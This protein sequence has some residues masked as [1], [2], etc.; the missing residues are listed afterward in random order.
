MLCDRAIRWQ[1]RRPPA[2][3]IGI[4][5]FAWRRGHTYASIVVDLERRQVIDLLPDWQC[6]TVMAWL[7]EN[8]QVEII[9]RDRGP[10]YVAA[11][12]EAAPRARQVAD[13]W[14][15]F[16]NASAACLPAVRS[17]IPSLRRA[18]SPSGPVDPATLTRAERLQWDGVQI[19]ETLNRQIL[20]LAG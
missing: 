1:N 17:E 7:R 8:P 6:E 20:D 16:E 11:A 12:T 2:R 4:D 3:V 15:L 10:R 5:D 18:L 14:H 19:Q 13:R 9:C